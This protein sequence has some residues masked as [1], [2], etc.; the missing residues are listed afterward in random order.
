MPPPLGAEVTRTSTTT[1]RRIR[2]IRGKPPAVIRVSAGSAIALG[3]I[4]GFLGASPTTAYLLTYLEGKC[5]GNCGFCSQAR[6]SKSRAD[7]LSRV[8][9][10][11]FRTDRAISKLKTAGKSGKIGRICIQ[12]L[13]YDGVVGDLLALLRELSLQRVGVP[14]SVSCH[15]LD[16]EAMD[17]L[18]KVGVERIGIPLDAATEEVFDRVKG[19]LAGGPYDWHSQRNT[20]LEAIEVFGKGKVSTHLIAGLGETEEELLKTIQWCVDNDIC[21]ALFSF[22]PVSGTALELKRPP[23][24][25][26]YRRVQLARYL[27]VRGATS[28]RKMTFDSY[29]RT[30]HFGVSRSERKRFVRTGEPFRTSGCPDCNRPYYNEKPSGPLYNF[31]IQ[32]TEHEVAEIEKQLL[33]MD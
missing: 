16:R 13:N 31:P 33:T 17:A 15:A 5:D 32:P 3:L 19:H 22:T 12:T 2:A 25:N 4:E 1:Q 9:W 6:S 23:E 26:Q 29:G 30:V 20:L 21:A 11:V 18:A 14:I 7:A 10:P 8:T 27:I 28:F 24:M